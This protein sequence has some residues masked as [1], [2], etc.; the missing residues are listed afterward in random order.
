[1]VAARLFLLAFALLLP[2]AARAQSG[3]PIATAE[4]QGMDSRAL[5][6]L[7][8]YGANAQMDSLVVVRN[9][10]LVAEA[11]YAPFQR[12]MRH[13]INSATK[14]VVGLLAGIAS[15]QGLLGSTEAP[16]LGLLADR[17]AANLD[18]RKQAI[19]LQHL[20]DMT[21]GI[22]WIEP[23]SDRVPESMIAME[24]SADW[25]QYILD[26]PMAQPPGSGFNYN[27]GGSHLVSAVLA[28][29]TGVSTEQ[30]AARQ[31]FAPLGIT[32]YRWLKDP[33]GVSIGGYGISMQT[34]DMARIGQLVLQRGE[35]DGRQLLPGAWV[36]RIFSAS[37]VMF[38][39]SG[40]RYGDFWWTLP[41]R[42]AY[43]AVG[44]NRQLI[45]VLPELNVVAAMT[46]RNHYPIEDVLTH[47][48]RSVRSA[49]ALP[50]DAQAAALLRERIRAAATEPAIP[51][52]IAEPALASEL[53]GKA[54]RL[55]P[56]RA[57][58]AQLTLNFGA[59]ASYELTTYVAPGSSETRRVTRPIGM[60]G[61]FSA[62]PADGGPLV[63]T[64]GEWTDASTLS[65]EQRW[66]QDGWT[67]WYLL[68]F[69]GKRVEI[70]QVDT[71][72]RRLTL[73]G[74]LD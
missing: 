32:D 23:L 18:P 63:V 66:P 54:W 52:G 73:A 34:P 22:D 5:A 56:N 68:R 48:E 58:L 3:W 24:R 28:R 50:D 11:Y 74:S 1:M 25:L 8:E 13:R 20:L 38:A 44:Y 57:G 27:S 43:L 51:A 40:W 15:G 36:D 53:S 16:V 45:I 70:T 60:Q 21:S 12:G 64:R 49:Q 72:G 59:E 41:Q 10:Q 9:G 69:D 62:L 55:E 35:W 61:R 47:L 26:R 29:K 19:T 4:S 17:T 46:G 39:A 65:I 71:F 33:Q 37:V 30:F 42:K 67:V 14:G 2:L 6:A 31:L 7:V